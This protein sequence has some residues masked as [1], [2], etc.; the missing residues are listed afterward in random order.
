[1]D[2]TPFGRYRLVEL[3]GEGG[4]GQVYRA[5]DT[6]TD[7]VV[8]L[9]VLPPH[10]AHDKV[11]RERFRRE[12]Q[13]AARLSE[14][15]VIP[16]HHYGEID[17]RLYLDMRLVEGTDLGSLLVLGGPLPPPKAVAYLEQIAAA[18]DAAHEAGLVHR[19]VKPSNVLVTAADFAYLIDFGIAAGTGESSLTTTGATIG[20]FAYM[21]P[22]RLTQGS[23]D[24]RAD[25][26]SLACV[27]YECLTGTK[28]FAGESAERQIAAHLT[29]PPPRPSNGQVSAAF[30][31]VIAR[32]MAKDPA[33]RYRT[34]G[35]LA[36]AARAAADAPR[37]SSRAPAT[38]PD[39]ARF[40]P[41][42]L[43]PNPSPTRPRRPRRAGIL[44]AVAALVAAL[45][46]GAVLVSQLQGKG[47]SGSISSAPPPPGEPLDSTSTPTMTTTRGA[48]SPTGV[49]PPPP[50]ALD[51]IAAFVQEHY[52]LLP[53]DPAAAW[54]RLTPR[55]QNYIGGYA[56]YRDFWGTVASTGVQVVDTDTGNLTATYRLTLR[57]VD[58]KVA[59]ETRVAVLVPVGEA[60]Q[61]DSAELTS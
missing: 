45:I 42:Q 51:S 47:E 55:Y 53:D 56:G 7:R 52:A 37:S 17:D 32:G 23:Y 9:K 13:A 57:Y 36:A 6:G 41:T 10:F 12:A 18:L 30:D 15:H 4:M 11:Y 29:E 43:N 35:E 61:I 46:V 14:P 58:G 24:G 33:R 59:T 27:L 44:V 19:D 3:L 50:Q 34:A 48:T 60:F 39:P 2:G 49:I 26:Y 1:M 5:F 54:G 21:A 28:P 31:D 25:V 16:I 40:D 8:A 20:T 22:E 38:V